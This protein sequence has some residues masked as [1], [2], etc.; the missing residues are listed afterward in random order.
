LTLSGDPKDVWFMQVAGSLDQAN[1]V[2]VTLAGSALAKNIFWQVAGAVTL[3]T[4]SY[5]DGIVLS[6]TLMAVNTGTSVNGQLL[7]QTAVTLQK[8]TITQPAE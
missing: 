4:N 5:F 8:N 6:K 3:G 2:R 1:I 7:A